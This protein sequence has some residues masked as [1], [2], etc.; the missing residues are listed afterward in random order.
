[1]MLEMIAGG[2]NT[3]GDA[4]PD[5]PVNSARG[6]GSCGIG[7]DQHFQHHAGALRRGCVPILT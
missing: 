3:K 1:M 7:I 6:E 2:Q 4:A 5:T